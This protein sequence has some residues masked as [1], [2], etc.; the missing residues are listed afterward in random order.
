MAHIISLGNQKGG[1]GKTTLT[2]NL[3]GHFAR[4]GKKV[5]I[6]D[7]DKQGSALDW[8]GVRQDESVFSVVGIPTDSVH[9]EIKNLAPNYDYIFIDAPPHS[10]NIL[11]SIILASDLFLIPL[12]PSA[13]D[14][15]SAEEVLK[16]LAEAVVFK[17][18]LKSA[19]VINRKIAN[20]T[21]TQSVKKALTNFKIPVFKS[22]ISQRVSFAES[23]SSGILIQE[24]GSDKTAIEEIANLAKE[25]DACLKN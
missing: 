10:A 9:K 21:I 13:L 2:I 16:L 4:A 24:L 22:I 3:A 11:R 23:M 18:N 12:T 19:F 20:T 7:A 5:L 17:E 1:V 8:Q 15:W 14:V 25:I 6:I